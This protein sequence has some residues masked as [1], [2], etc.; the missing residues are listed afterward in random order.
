MSSKTTEAGKLGPITYKKAIVP[1]DQEGP[2][3]EPLFINMC[4]VAFHDDVVYIDVGIIPL[5]EVLNRTGGTELTFDVLNRLVM[6]VPTLKN[7]RD[8]ISVLLDSL[9]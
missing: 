5:D 3:E 2:V 4:E 7:L 9:E 6:G 8:Q 1:F